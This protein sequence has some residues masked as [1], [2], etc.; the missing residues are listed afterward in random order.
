MALGAAYL[1][2]QTA[3]LTELAELYPSAS[4]PVDNAIYAAAIAEYAAALEAQATLA[5]RPMDSYST[6]GVS[7]NFRDAGGASRTASS[8]AVRLARAG[9]SINAGT[10]V[11]HDIRGVHEPIS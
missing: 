2:I 10:P 6:L 7:M 11:T 1:A 8:L 3:L 4:S 9:F 5:A